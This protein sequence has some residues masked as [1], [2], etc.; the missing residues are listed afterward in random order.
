MWP[1]IENILN[2]F[3][4]S[5]SRWVITNHLGQVSLFWVSLIKL[6]LMVNFA[7]FKKLFQENALKKMKYLLVSIFVIFYIL[8]STDDLKNLKDDLKDPQRPMKASAFASE[9]PA[10]FSPFIPKGKNSQII[11]LKLHP[12]VGRSNYDFLNDFSLSRWRDQLRH[13]YQKALPNGKRFHLFPYN[14]ST[15]EKRKSSDR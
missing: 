12:N 5:L 3:K 1:H 14:M 4:I 2:L 6:S 15:G 13:V 10:P 9:E 8:W 11:R 7:I